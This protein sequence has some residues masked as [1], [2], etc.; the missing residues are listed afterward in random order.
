MTHDHREWD[1]AVDC[2]KPTKR[3]LP[4]HITIDYNRVL[5]VLVSGLDGGI[6]YWGHVH[7]WEIPGGADRSW[8][9]DQEFCDNVDQLYLAPFLHGWIE[10]KVD[11]EEGPAKRIDLSRLGRALDIMAEKYPKHFTDILCEN[12]DAITGD[13]LIQLA[14]FEEIVYG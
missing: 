14:I 6:R 7:R 5:D 4:L 13:V 2:D 9:A 8:L 12:D 1:N 3:S 10:I 11:E